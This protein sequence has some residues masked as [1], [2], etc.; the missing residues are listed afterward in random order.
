MS[1]KYDIMIML[2]IKHVESF[3]FKPKLTYQLSLVDC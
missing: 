3:D 2:S 1:K